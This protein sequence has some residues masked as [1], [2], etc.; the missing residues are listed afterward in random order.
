LT[1]L[2]DGVKTVFYISKDQSDKPTNPI[3]YAR[4][5]GSSV[6]FQISSP[7]VEGLKKLPSASRE[8]KAPPD[9][10]KGK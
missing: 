1:V 2:H 10:E 9:K 6:V 4:M 7:F 8:E 5:E 3:Y